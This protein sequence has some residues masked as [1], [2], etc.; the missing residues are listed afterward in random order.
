M[1]IFFL[2]Q[3]VVVVAELNSSCEEEECT[4]VSM[5]ALIISNRNLYIVCGCYNSNR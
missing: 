3:I 1:H 5:S 4:V 2:F